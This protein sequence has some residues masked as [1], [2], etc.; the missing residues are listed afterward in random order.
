MTVTVAAARECAWTARTDASWLQLSAPG[1]EGTGSL[2][3]TAVSNGLQSVR[4]ARVAVNNQ[5]FVVT[6]AARSCRFEVQPESAQV[7]G[8]GGGGRIE[9]QATAGCAWQATSSD[10]W[11]RLPNS[12]GRTGSGSQDFEVSANDGAAR[13]AVIRIGDQSFAVAQSAGT[14]GSSSGPQPPV[15]LTSTVLSDTS[16]VLRWTNTDPGAETQVSR[17]GAVVGVTG[18]GIS[19]YQDAALT[20]GASYSYAVRHVKN[21]VAGVDSNVVVARPAFM[22]SGGTVSIAGGYRRHVFTSSGTFVVTQGGTI[23]EIVIVAGGGGGGGSE[24]GT[25]YGSGAGGAGGVRVI[26]ARFESPGSYAVIV[27]GGGGGGRSASSNPANNNGGAGGSSSYGSVV[28]LGGGGGA[29]AATN[30]LGNPGGSGGSGGGGTGAAGGAGQSGDG[31]SGGAGFV[32]VGGATGGGGGGSRMSAGAPGIGGNGGAGGAAYQTWNGP[33]A[34]GGDGGRGQGALE[35]MA[36]RRAMVATAIRRVEAE[37]RESPASCSSA[38][39]SRPGRF[40]SPAAVHGSG[41]RRAPS[42]LDAIVTASCCPACHSYPQSAP[43]SPIVPCPRCGARSSM[44]RVIAFFILSPFAVALLAA[45]LVR[46]APGAARMLAV[47]PALLTIVLSAELRSTLTAGQP[48][49]RAVLGA[50]ARPVALVQPRRPGAAVRAAHHRDRHA[51]RPL[52]ERV[53]EGSSAGGPLLRVALRLHGRD[54]RRGAQRQHPHAVR[55][56]GTDRLHVVPADRLRTRARRRTLGRV[57]GT[58]RDRRRRSRAAGRRRAAPRRVGHHQPVGDGVEPGVDRRA[59]VLRRDRG[60]DAARRVHE[61][62]AGAVSFLAAERDGGAD[63]GQRLSALGDHG[64]GR[65]L[66]RSRG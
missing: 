38:I 45:W 27:G 28:S 62:G 40:L 53:P 35:A 64:Q 37:G 42:R 55:L 31:N 6:Q 22:A 3:V 5:F 7:S 8:A 66:S 47:W 17:N 54:A 51:G 41:W 48:A 56:L 59:S 1:A 63:A 24:A 44:N 15:N 16:V 46:R 61:V 26:T 65:R 12:A 4:T 11:V 49:G 20:R 43:H 50:V 13:N 25:E 32:N 23:A 18:A 34:A 14:G 36:P 33:V 19:S 58:D 52:R 9:V 10:A 57:A 29:G 30:Y 2:V 60:P 39:C 21:G